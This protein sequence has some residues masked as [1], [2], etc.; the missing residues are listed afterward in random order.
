MSF[1]HDGHTPGVNGSQVGVLKKTDQVT[2][3]SLL[4][5]QHCAALEAQILFE[6]LHSFPDEAL[7]WHL[8][9]E[10]VRAPLVFADLLPRYLGGTCHRHNF[11]WVFR[12]SIAKR[13]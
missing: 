11:F 2:F 5:G 4:Q 3:S 1:G 9:D 12:A 8:A 7:E 13:S 6:V 10:Q